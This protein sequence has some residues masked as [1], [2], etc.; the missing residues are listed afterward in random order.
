MT[1]PRTDHRKD[2][3]LIR[4]M[5]E[6]AEELRQAC[7]ELEQTADALDAVDVLPSLKNSVAE[8]KRRIKEAAGK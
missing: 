5:R 2:A 6:R 7:Y 3:T 8:A 1:E 4:E